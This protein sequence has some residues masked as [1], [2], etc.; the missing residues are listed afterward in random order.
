MD[1][2][3]I[4]TLTLNPCID[5]TVQVCAFRPGGTNRAMSSREDIG[6]KG[7]NVSRVLRGCGLSVLTAGIAS[8]DSKERIESEFAANGMP[9]LFLPAEGRTRVNLKII[10]TETGDMTELNETGSPVGDAADR[11]REALL[12]YL[13]DAQVLVLSG[14]LPP[15]VSPA[16]YRDCI[17][18]ARR[19]GVKTILDADNE[20]MRLGVQ[21]SP[22]AV[23]PN[24]S[25]LEH[26]AGMPLHDTASVCAQIQK[27]HDKGVSL[28]CVSMGADG[29]LF[30]QNGQTLRA[31]PFPIA[32]GSPAAAGD[33]MAAMLA[34]GIAKQLPL[35]DM[36][37][38]A[39]AAGTCTAEKAGTQTADYPQI[40]ARANAIQIRK[41]NVL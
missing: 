6:G 34:F 12:P 7:L 9:T 36:A 15:D 4:I 25:E 1:R 29:A 28:V 14:S 8:A 23:K 19:Y 18:T 35:D 22:Y 3:K 16:F 39:C 38:L 5:K 21:A 41:E 37:R 24:L 40:L 2:P 27:L 33:A 32:V 11:L 10:D 31:V 26:W 17:L 20:A 13:T 30:S